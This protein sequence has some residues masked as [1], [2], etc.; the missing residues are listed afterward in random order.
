MFAVLVD[1]NV[2]GTLF[3][4]STPNLFHTFSNILNDNIPTGYF[5]GFTHYATLERLGLSIPKPNIILPSTLPKHTSSQET[6]DI[7]GEETCRVLDYLRTAGKQH[8]G[9]YISPIILENKF[10]EQQANY[11]K[12]DDEAH[13][14]LQRL[15]PVEANFFKSV[16]H[17]LIELLAIDFQNGYSQ[18]PKRL[19]NP[20]QAMNILS[21]MVE[22]SKP[23]NI[24]LGRIFKKFWLTNTTVRSSSKISK[25]ALQKCHDAMIFRNSEDFVDL[26]ITYMTLM[27]YYR[28]KVYRPVIS[29][30]QDP[31]DKVIRRLYIVKAMMDA[32]N[33]D[34]FFQKGYP[35]KYTFGKILIV[36]KDLNLLQEIH[37][38]HLKESDLE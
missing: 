28:D 27:G 29:I 31:A 32:F 37:P 8:Y 16:A 20:V 7:F 1:T 21:L 13:K 5:F 30:T 26:E 15:L 25:E 10:S 6:V 12:N 23:R 33:K 22:F 17:D 36:D 11:W 2:F 34:I 14:L 3:K 24:V 38:Q 9:T 4:K 18:L 35:I 19:E